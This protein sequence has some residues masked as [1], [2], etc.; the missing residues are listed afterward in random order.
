[1][2]L[3]KLKSSRCYVHHILTSIKLHNTRQHCVKVSISSYDL[4]VMLAMSYIMSGGWTYEGM[5]NKN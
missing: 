2:M 4:A 3:N 5:E 1:M